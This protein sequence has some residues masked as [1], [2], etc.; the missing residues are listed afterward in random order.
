MG[1]VPD[2][3]AESI[4]NTVGQ[5]ASSRWP[6]VPP[7]SPAV[8]LWVTTVLV[9]LAA[10]A[11]W[12]LRDFTTI[13]VLATLLAYIL[14]PP[15][16]YLQ[17]RAGMRRGWATVLVY[18]TVAFV[19]IVSSTIIAQSV[20]GSL[21]DL[22][23]RELSA[24][25]TEAAFDLLPSELTFRDQTIEIQPMYELVE[26]ELRTGLRSL[27]SGML[28]PSA[29][30]Q[31]LGRATGLA[32]DFLWSA[33][34]LMAIFFVSLYFAIDGDGILA[35]IERKVPCD[36]HPAYHALRAEVDL[37]WRRFF[38]GQLLLAVII[39]VITTL[40]LMLLG[41]SYAVPLGIIAGILEVIPRLGPVLSVI[42]AVFV[43]A[44]MPSA[45]MPDLPRLWLVVAVVVLYIAIQN[46]ENNILVPRILGDSVNLPPAVVLLGALAGAKVAGVTGIL[47]AA[48]VL[49]S[50]RII[51]SWLYDQ[52]TRC[53]DTEPTPP[54]NEAPAPSNSEARAPDEEGTDS[55]LPD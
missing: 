16:C 27:G 15:I 19:F 48:P 41:V 40:G 52:L 50:A 39:G 37:V 7:W 18:G 55:A 33:L 20:A 10:M 28:G 47:L 8:R 44:V 51:C 1:P 9:I 36:F 4:A 31:L 12:R 24:A 3:D 17:R 22:D 43:A 38:R 35:W 32:T 49:G 34:G 53:S 46:L 2:Q 5:P 14:N 29:V 42:P 6:Y 23:P 30:P 21:S 25:L 11:W 54:N 13:V 26:R 45:T